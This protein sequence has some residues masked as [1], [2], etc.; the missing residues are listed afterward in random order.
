MVSVPVIPVSQF[1]VLVSHICWLFLVSTQHPQNCCRGLS[2]FGGL[3]GVWVD[4]MVAEIVSVV[5]LGVIVLLENL[6][7]IVCSFHDSVLGGCQF[8]LFGVLV[9]VSLFVMVA[10]LVC[11]SFCHFV[12]VW[13]FNFCQLWCCFGCLHPQFWVQDFVVDLRY[14]LLFCGFCCFVE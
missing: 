11:L 7:C 14:F 10:M 9:A 3:S 8:S 13:V 12:L 6:P 4:C 2:I 1:L 5:K